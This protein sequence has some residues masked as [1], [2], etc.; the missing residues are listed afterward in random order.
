MKLLKLKHA[1]EIYDMWY[2]NQVM[3]AEYAFEGDR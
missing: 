1:E 3:A 2:Q